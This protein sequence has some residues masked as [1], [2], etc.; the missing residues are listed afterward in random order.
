MATLEADYTQALEQEEQLMENVE[1]IV[2]VSSVESNDDKFARASNDFNLM[3]SLAKDNYT[4]AYYPLAIMYFDKGDNNSA[5]NWANKAIKANMNRVSAQNL[6]AKIE[7]KLFTK[8]T[9]LEDYMAL[10]N[11]GYKKA[12][13]RLAEMYLRNHNYDNAHIWALRARDAKTGL[14]KARN[15]V[16][17]LDSYGYYDN[18]E[19]GGKPN[20]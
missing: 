20:F 6:L 11:N 13:A 17:V 19:H 3:L 8:A 2:P 15:V 9:T 5:I 12:Y 16:D 1:P 18:G 10:A 4:K 14:D 7:D